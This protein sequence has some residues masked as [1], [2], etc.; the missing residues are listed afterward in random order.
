M[1]LKRIAI[2]FLTAVMSVNCVL[3]VGASAEES[4]NHVVHD[5]TEYKTLEEQ[6]QE[7]VAS[8]YVT[9]E[10]IEA[11]KEQFAE[12]EAIENGT[13]V[14]PHIASA[15][16]SVPYYAQE[17]KYYCGPATVRQTY[18]SLNKT[19]NGSSYA[20]SQST[21]A[22]AIGTTS[23]GSDQN[24]M[25]SYLNN[26]FPSKAYATYWKNGA[27][28]S[29]SGLLNH[30]VTDVSQNKPTIAHVIINST[31]GTANWNYT[32]SRHYLNYNGYTLGISAGIDLI[33]VTDPNAAGHGYATGKYSIEKS[34]AY[35]VT[36]RISS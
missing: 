1:K 14:M 11:F 4:E 30:I 32:T 3:S 36:D 19:I 9:E 21:I 34:N 31:G 18:S 6:Y 33:D 17:T 5:A 26:I 28:T 22:Q 12:R 27:Y 15:G 25:N 35:A 20:P 8:D 16:V 2:A 13:N 10:G 23:D 24:R 7:Y 29:D